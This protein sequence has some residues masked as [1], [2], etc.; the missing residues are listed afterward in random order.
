MVIMV[1]LVTRNLMTT[2][3]N[4]G[5]QGHHHRVLLSP[6][7][8]TDV[9]PSHLQMPALVSPGITEYTVTYTVVL[10]WNNKHISI[11]IDFFLFRDFF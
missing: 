6:L 5:P 1:I 8:H 11:E 9:T 4:Q 7:C 2:I 3:K 10:Y